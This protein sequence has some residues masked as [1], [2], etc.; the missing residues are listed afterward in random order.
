MK[1]FRDGPK[2]AAGTVSEAATSRQPSVS[3]CPGQR[4]TAFPPKPS[5]FSSPL[6]GSPPE[7]RLTEAETRVISAN[8]LCASSISDGWVATRR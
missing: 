4:E 1:T 3:L 7:G 2:W 6:A 5:Y 8:C